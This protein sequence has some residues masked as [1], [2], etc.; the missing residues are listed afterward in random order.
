MKVAVT[1][2]K[3]TGRLTLGHYLGL[4]KPTLRY[5]NDT[6]LFFF[7]ADLHALTLHITPE[8][9]NKY[10]EELIAT[11]LAVGYD[12]HPNVTFFLQSAVSSHTEIAYLLSSQTYLGELSRMIQFKEKKGNHD[13]TRVALFTYPILMAGDILL[14]QPDFVPIGQDQKQH[15]ELTRDIAKRINSTYNKQLFKI[16]EGVISE[17]TKKIKSLS[18]PEKKM[19]KSDVSKDTIYLLDDLK[20]VRKKIMSAVTDNDGKI[21]YDEVNKPGISNLL[22]IYSGLTNKSIEDI[23]TQYQDSGYGAFKK[24]LADL[25]C[26]ELNEIQN[27]YNSLISN[28]EYLKT[29]LEKGNK[30]AREISIKTLEEFKKAI[31]LYHV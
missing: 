1:G 17:N 6:K 12:K 21:Y 23:V 11:V 25:V 8:D 2:I 18:N 13:N 16:P 22:N 26:N 20:T 3:P 15:L 28:K 27:K 14:Y 10:T 29:I 9:L 4:L 30:E 19:S 5:I 31:G 7:A 24:D